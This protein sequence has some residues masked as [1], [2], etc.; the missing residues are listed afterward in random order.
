MPKCPENYCVKIKSA[1]KTSDFNFYS[2]SFS[3]DSILPI[4]IKFVKK[5]NFVYFEFDFFLLIFIPC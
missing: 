4:W 3:V 5:N 1:F 2:N